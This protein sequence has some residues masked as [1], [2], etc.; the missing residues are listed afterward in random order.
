MYVG[1]KKR[2]EAGVGMSIAIDL[3]SWNPEPPTGGEAHTGL[4]RLSEKSVWGNFWALSTKHGSCNSL[5]FF[6]EIKKLFCP[7]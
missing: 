3:A 5:L 6:R 1:S 7:I 4:L 2:V